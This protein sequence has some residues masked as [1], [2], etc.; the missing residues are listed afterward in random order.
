MFEQPIKTLFN[1]TTDEETNI[2]FKERGGNIL[3]WVK[4]NLDRFNL[5]EEHS[6]EVLWDTKSDIITISGDEDLVELQIKKV[7]FIYT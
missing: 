6:C 3:Y 2:N 4:N 7:E 5:N 1:L